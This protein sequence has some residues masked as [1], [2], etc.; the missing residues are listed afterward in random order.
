MVGVYSVKYCGFL[1]VLRFFHGFKVI[2][3]TVN[4]GQLPESFCI[5]HH[6]SNDV[7]LTLDTEMMEHMFKNGSFLQCRLK[8][9]KPS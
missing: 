4:P 8:V 5:N 1:A 2:G 7:Y 6:I 9:H 3:V